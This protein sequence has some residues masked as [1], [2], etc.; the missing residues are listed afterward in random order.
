MEGA[1]AAKKKIAEMSVKDEVI[2]FVKAK[3]KKEWKVYVVLNLI[4]LVS[5]LF[6]MYCQ[7]RMNRHGASW[8]TP[9]IVSLY[10]QFNLKDWKFWTFPA[11]SLLQQ[12]LL[13][14]F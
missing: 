1:E 6:G 9:K 13:A 8:G 4:T 14:R 7:G 3:V 5:W 2:M 12:S 11:H 10:T